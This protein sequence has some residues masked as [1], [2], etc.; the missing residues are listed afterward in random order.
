ML[1]WLNSSSA[2]YLRVIDMQLLRVWCRF[3]NL[4]CLLPDCPFVAK[5]LKNRLQWYALKYIR[6]QWK[7]YC[8][9]KVCICFCRTILRSGLIKIFL[10]KYGILK[11]PVYV[12]ICKVY[13]KSYINYPN[14]GVL[15]KIITWAIFW[16]SAETIYG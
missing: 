2:D 5:C 11:T 1:L 3:W 8:I 14:Y 15:L 7:Y 4:G 12:R 16:C 13:L 10:E 6:E 9:W